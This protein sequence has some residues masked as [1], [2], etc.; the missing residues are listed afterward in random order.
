MSMPKRSRAEHGESAYIGHG[1]RHPRVL[2]HGGASRR[3]LAMDDA[4]LYWIAE[5]EG[6]ITR[7]RKSGGVPVVLGNTRRGRA[8]LHVEG[9]LYWAQPGNR[10]ATGDDAEG[11]VMR[12]PREG[13][14][15]EV[16]LRGLD[17]PE[18]LA[19]SGDDLAVGCAG[20]WSDDVVRKPHWESR[21]LVVRASAHGAGHAERVISQQ[22]GPCSLLFAG[23]DLYWA[24]HGY[25]GSQYFADG[26]IV[27]V[28]RSG[29][30]ELAVVASD[31][32]MADTLIA[33]ERHVYWTTAATVHAPVPYRRGG[34]YR[35]PREGG[36]HEALVEWDRE[37]GKLA[38]DA[39]HVYWMDHSRGA[40]YRLPKQ[41]GAPEPMMTSV[42]WLL[43]CDGILVDDQYVFWTVWDPAR[44]GGAVWCIAKDPPSSSP[45][46][47]PPPILN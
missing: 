41:G 29:A 40:L 34:I 28:P 45:S 42:E 17:G 39:T 13:G 21:G 18:C 44:A 33:D 14:T 43:L 15:P 23:D 24:N 1:G 19:V 20:V 47:E 6:E 7:L 31:Q 8:L 36:A 26:S 5:E 37:H 30:G 27:R 46:E 25:K 4:H 10:Y 9:W 16:L 3:A 12:M 2:A 35:L 32:A 11:K 22:R 38:M